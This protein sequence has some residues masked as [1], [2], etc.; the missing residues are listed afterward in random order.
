MRIPVTMQRLAPD[1][2]AG[3]IVNWLVE[4]GD[5][6]E[7]GDELVEVGADKADVTMESMDAGTLVEIVA[8][9]DDEVEIGETIAYLE[10]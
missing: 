4:I 8:A 10:A 6:I 7:L 1:M 9:V 3:T 5:E 2:T